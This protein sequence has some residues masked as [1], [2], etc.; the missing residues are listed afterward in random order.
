M[1]P[2]RPVSSY[3]T[4]SPLLPKQ[5][6]FSVTL[7]CLYR[8][9][10]VKKYGALC[11]PDFPL[12]FPRATDCP[13]VKIQRYGISVVLPTSL[14]KIDCKNTINSQDFPNE[15]RSIHL[16]WHFVI[17]CEVVSRWRNSQSFLIGF[18]RIWGI[19]AS[20]SAEILRFTSFHA[21]CTAWYE[22]LHYAFVSFRMTIICP[23]GQMQTCEES[24]VKG[25]FFSF[26]I[27][28]SQRGGRRFRKGVQ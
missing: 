6:L 19:P 28:S 27:V 23:S 20:L 3:L 18:V 24:F 7:L 5:R 15:P 2:Q 22:I 14:H 9:L 1:S 12:A 17:P 13:A 16:R 21:K 4:F 8:Q 11:C 25:L 10:P 26:V